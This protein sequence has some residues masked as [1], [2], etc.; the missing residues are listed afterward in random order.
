[1]IEIKVRKIW[2][3]KVVIRDKYLDVIM[4]TK[5]D[6]LIRSG[7]E[8]MII[9]FGEV[10]DRIVAKSE[11]PFKDKFSNKEHYLVYFD[12]QPTTINKTLFE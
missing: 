10:M 12:W 2:Q 4:R 7:G 6:V 8:M 3:G 9:P 5:E 1:M 11:K